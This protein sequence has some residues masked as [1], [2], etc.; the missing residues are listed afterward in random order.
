MSLVQRRGEQHEGADTHA[1]SAGT[2]GVNSTQ[3]LFQQ[4]GATREQSGQRG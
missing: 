3:T 1:D 2:G 4:A